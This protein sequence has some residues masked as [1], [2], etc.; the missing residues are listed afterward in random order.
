MG[1][2]FNPQGLIDMTAGGI[3][4][5]AL[6][7][8]ND[9]RQYRQQE[10]LQAL[11]IAGMKEMADYNY[12]KQ[13]DMWNATNVG[14]QVDHYKKAGMNP[15]LIYGMKGGGGVTTGSPGGGPSGAQAPQGGR[16][17]QELMGMGL[18]LGMMKAQIEKTKAET[19]NIETDTAKKGGVDTQEAQA[20]IQSLMQGVTESQAKT[21]L[22]KVD[23]MLRQL[24]VKVE[25]ESV[26][27]RIDYIE[28]MARKMFREVQIADDAQ[29]VSHATRNARVETVMAELVGIGL[30]NALTQ[31]QTTN[32]QSATAVNR[33]QITQWV[34]NNMRE[35][36][37]M[38]QENRK[39]AVM[40]LL[41]QHNTDPTTEAMRAIGGL[42][43]NLFIIAPKLSQTPR[44]V[45]E[46]FG[47]KKY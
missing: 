43:D 20:R 45:V 3:L 5:L 30:R 38:T 24:E 39:I 29:Y 16:E 14:A 40:E 7:P 32:T 10:K 9:H 34:Q 17:I 12:N 1:Y 27:A 15:A 19:K 26:E 37:K 47:K 33:E 8:I 25:G 23:T 36:D 28:Y 2:Q 35:W 6:G 41:Q 21:A 46:G 11:Q 31:A 13:L 42:L 4:G 44:T 22:T 18:Q